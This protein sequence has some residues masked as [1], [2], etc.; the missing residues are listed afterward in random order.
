[1]ETLVLVGLVMVGVGALIWV[2]AQGICPAIETDKCRIMTL[3]GVA[4]GTVKGPGITW[5]FLKGI[6]YDFVVVPRVF[7]IPVKVEFALPEETYPTTVQDVVALVRVA[8]DGGAKL[9]INGGQEGTGKKVA[10]IVATEIE[11]FAADPGEEPKNLD[12]AKRMKNDFVLR[13]VNELVDNNLREQ[14]D[15]LAPADRI[16][17]IK[18]I[19]AQLSDNGAEYPMSVFGL[20]LIGFSMGRFV[21]PSAVTEVAMKKKVAEQ[22]RDILA[23]NARALKARQEILRE[24]HPNAS[25]SDIAKALQVQEGKITHNV[26][27]QIIRV[28]TTGDDPVAKLI[29]GAVAAFSPKGTG[30][31]KGGANGRKR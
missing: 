24:G 22:E 23:E 13:A 9:L 28:E 7:E 15:N 31:P 25:F 6:L 16:K 14:A 4:T 20:T 18:K 17:F 2:I 8:D 10:R 19:E 26:S 21:E 29:A 5:V 11:E 3:R 30:E 12:T 27:E 1:M